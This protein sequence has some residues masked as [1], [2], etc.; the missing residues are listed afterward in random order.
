MYKIEELED[1][2]FRLLV[3][4]PEERIPLFNTAKDIVA[5]VLR[6]VGPPKESVI[7]IRPCKTPS[8]TSD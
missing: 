6:L 8:K 7:E 1:E 5:A 2:V 4:I 3:K